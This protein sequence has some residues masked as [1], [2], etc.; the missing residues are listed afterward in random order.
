MYSTE[1]PISE[2]GLKMTTE[3]RK[4]EKS[5]AKFF[6]LVAMEIIFAYV[7]AGLD[8]FCYFFAS[9]QKSKNTKIAVQP[10]RY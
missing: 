3:I 1:M 5:R 4:N 8:F 6:I 9:R 7:A 2:E 10:I